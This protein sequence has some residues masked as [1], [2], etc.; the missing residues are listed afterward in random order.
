LPFLVKFQD[1]TG[2]L[3]EKRRREPIPHQKLGL[4]LLNVS[5]LNLLAIFQIF[6]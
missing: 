4:H 3:G 2:V 6:R 1:C 5:P